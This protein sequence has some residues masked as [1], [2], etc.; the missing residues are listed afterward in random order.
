MATVSE[1]LA[2]AYSQ[3][4]I[5]EDPANSNI[6]KYNDWYYGRRVQGPAYPWCMVFMQWLYNQVGVKL[7]LRTASCGAMLT[8]AKKA[9]CYV[10][11]NYK[12]GDLLLFDF[13]GQR[14]K[15]T[16]CGILYKLYTIDNKVSRVQSIE[17]NTSV[18]NDSNGGEVMLRDRALS[19]IMGAVR[20]I[21]D[22]EVEDMTADEFIK[23]LTNKQAYDILTKA[24][25]HAATLSEPDWSKKEGHW[26]NATSKGI[27]D[28]KAPERLVKRDEL[29]AILGRMGL[30]EK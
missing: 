4:G 13:T 7:P 3:L 9:G 23:N 28:G 17:G 20:P 11:T 6:V 1:I 24:A 12:P 26:K 8:A 14:F 21:F 15:T 18:G 25:T 16:H 2:L 22:K 29:T 27:V 19:T 5:K 10:T 30:I